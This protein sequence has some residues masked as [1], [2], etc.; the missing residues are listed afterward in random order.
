MIKSFACKETKALF[1]R[2]TIRK[3]PPDIQRAALR[4]LKILD[5]AVDVSDLKV[6]PGNRL[7][8]LKGSRQD[9]YSIRI[10]EQWRICFNF[11]HAEATN[12]EIVDYH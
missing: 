8:K 2:E 6:P 11:E 3:I 1:D 7:E 9:Q 12:V 10:N 5:A 4:K